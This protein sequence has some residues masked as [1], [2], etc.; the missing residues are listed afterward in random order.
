MKKLIVALIL[1]VV[2]T[3]TFAAPAFAGPPEDK[4]GPGKGTIGNDGL[5]NAGSHL[6][7][8]YYKTYSEGALW[9]WC[10]ISSFYH[11]GYGPP[12]WFVPPWWAS[13]PK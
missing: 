9:A 6:E 2:L 5:W 11:Q 10:I 3:V 1:A 8:V 12:P 13:G 4:P 7:E